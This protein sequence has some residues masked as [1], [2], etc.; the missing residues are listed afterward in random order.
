[1]TVGLSPL[2]YLGIKEG[3]ATRKLSPCSA[4]VGAYTE[5]KRI[6]FS[7]SQHV[8]VNYL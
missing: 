8:P 1:M 7:E 2:F 4:V 5:Q 3:I 6:T